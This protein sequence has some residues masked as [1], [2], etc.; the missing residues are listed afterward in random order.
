MSAANAAAK[1]RRAPT[2]VIEYNTSI[3]PPRVPQPPA[4]LTIY[5]VVALFD[6]RIGALEKT[7]SEF[8]NAPV[9]DTD[10]PP[11]ES[12]SEVYGLIKSVELDVDELKSTVMSLQKYTLSVNHMLL[13][14]SG[15]IIPPPTIPTPST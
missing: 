12:E 11:S 3:P 6:K 15:V 7:I 14:N 13:E 4:G 5:E 10:E 1:K 9:D 2:S 8:M